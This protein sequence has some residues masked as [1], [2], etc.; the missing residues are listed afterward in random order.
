MNWLHNLIN[1]LLAW[2]PRLWMVNPDE[3]GV[4][5]TLGSRVKTLVPGW[6]VYWPLMQEC[7]NIPSTPQ[8]I[9]LRSQSLT[10]KNGRSVVISGAVEYSIRDAEKAIL[11]IQDYDKSLPTLCLG[12]IA[13]YVETHD[14]ENCKSVV[15][16]EALRKEIRE[17]VNAWGIAV[18]HIFITDNII[19]KTYRVMLRNVRSVE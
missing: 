12:K 14:F 3:S 9:D 15:I 16:K 7:I 8:V 4:R 13:E 6:Y 5:I 19:A 11:K 2:I 18:K 17:H 10:T 1:K